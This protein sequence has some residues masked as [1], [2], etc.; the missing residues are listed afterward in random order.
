MYAPNNRAS[1]S[2]RQKQIE[3]QGNVNDSTSYRLQQP[4]RN[5]HIQLAEI[6]KDIVEFNN[7]MNQLDIINIYKSLHPKTAENIFLNIYF[8]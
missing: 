8:C 3:L 5:R 7:T 6:S 4:L 2:M 1:N